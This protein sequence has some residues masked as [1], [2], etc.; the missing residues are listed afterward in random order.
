MA[1]SYPQIDPVALSLG[2]L[3]IR[4]YALAYVSALLIG[5]RYC[6][7]IARRQSEWRTGGPVSPEAVDDF[8]LWATLGV[9]LGGR[10]GFAAFYQPGYF[11]A[12]PLALG[13]LWQGGMSFHG[14]LLGVTAALVIYARRRR[15]PVLALSDIVARAV[16]VGLFFGRI[17]NFINGE[18]FG[19]PADLPWAM[20]F[21]QG[22]PLAR[23]PSQIYEAL[24]EGVFLFL[25]VWAIARLAGGERRRG[26]VTGG[27]VTLY[28]AI[29]FGL[30]NFR[31]PDSY[32]G[33]FSFG[34]TMGQ[35]LSIP[36]FA[37]GLFLVARALSRP[38][39]RPPAD[40][41]S[42]P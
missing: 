17:A 32:L 11:L 5:W 36:L 9:V 3:H 2:P 39:S 13:A 19:R 34:L 30:E 29:R 37:F 26:L 7:S 27:F 22:G 15:F 35:I 41:N 25:A 16:P 20:V 33:Y 42:A 8:L 21:P 28:A 10:L 4:W 18:L 31:E 12:H 40:G 24:G 1:L 23:H 6:L 38:L 14:G